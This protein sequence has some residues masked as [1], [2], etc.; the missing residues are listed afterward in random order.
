MSNIVVMFCNK[1]TFH[2]ESCEFV[3]CHL[4]SVVENFFSQATTAPLAT[5]ASCQNQKVGSKLTH[6]CPCVST[7]IRTDSNGIVAFTSG[8]DCLCHKA[9]AKPKEGPRGSLVK[10]THH[11]TTNH[12]PTSHVILELHSY[13]YVRCRHDKRAQGEWQSDWDYPELGRRYH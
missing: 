11:R 3:H 7:F 5:Q 12:Q 8:E 6:W 4:F 13:K 2:D 9:N 10:T 1:T